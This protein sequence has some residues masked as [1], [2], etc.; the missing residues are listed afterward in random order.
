M[1]PPNEAKTYHLGVLRSAAL[2][3]LEFYRVLRH[4]TQVI[5]M[6]NTKL[7]R[8][9]LAFRSLCQ[10]FGGVCVGSLCDEVKKKV[11]MLCA[12]FTTKL[13]T[14][15]SRKKY[16]TKRFTWIVSVRPASS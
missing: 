11:K 13:L 1:K 7:R 12:L 8:T 10:V 3:Y 2:S 9:S 15:V 6:K 4:P 5:L 14:L 16:S